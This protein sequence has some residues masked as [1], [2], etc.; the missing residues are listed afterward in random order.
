MKN[1]FLTLGVIILIGILFCLTNNVYA[2][3]EET[4]TNENSK[5]G[6]LVEKYE[7][8]TNRIENGYDNLTDT[9]EKI[10]EKGYNNINISYD[11][12]DNI[13]KKYLQKKQLFNQL[14]EKKS[15]SLI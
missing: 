11:A 1:K 7:K 8:Y 6:Y 15:K 14:K 13:K 5:K 4:N 12:I 9:I 10:Y 3:T 2:N